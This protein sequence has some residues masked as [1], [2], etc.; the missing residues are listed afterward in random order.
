MVHTYVVLYT[1]T[2]SCFGCYMQHPPEPP[3]HLFQL[4]DCLIN[5]R[6]S[7][8]RLCGK[9]SNYSSSSGFTV[10]STFLD[11]MTSE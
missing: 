10:C 11:R 3:S 9:G 8:A 1:N 5:S 6:A 7:D 4:V 2:E